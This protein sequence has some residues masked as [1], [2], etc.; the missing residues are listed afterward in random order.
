ML[1]HLVYVSSASRLFRPEDLADILAV[2]RRNNA[3]AG[4]TGL[5]LYA[6]GTIIQALEGPPSAVDEAYARIGRDDRHRGA[7][8]LLREPTAERSFPEWAMGFRDVGALT[9]VEG[10]GVRPL[11]EGGLAPDTFA[12]APQRAHRLLRSFAALAA[13]GAL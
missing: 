3:R 7:Q 5:L 2:S 11:L 9:G 13:T 6:G 8:V 1:V 10:D 12:G 4:I